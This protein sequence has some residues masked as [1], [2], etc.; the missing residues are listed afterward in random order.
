M[1]ME[2]FRMMGDGKRKEEGTLEGFGREGGNN[3]MKR[4]YVCLLVGS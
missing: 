2:G 3:A 1:K 4:E